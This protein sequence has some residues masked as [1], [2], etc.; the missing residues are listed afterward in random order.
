V[1]AAGVVVGG[2]VVG[3]VVGDVVV[4]GVVVEVV[5]GE[6]VEVGRVVVDGVVPGVKAEVVEA[7]W[8][9]GAV[10]GVVPPGADVP[11]TVQVRSAAARL[12]AAAC[13]SRSAVC[14]AVTTA[15]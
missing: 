10:V 14:W 5:L 11:E 4:V 8:W 15:C 3:A 7:L 1:L 12:A 2:V 13:M 9:L 6:V